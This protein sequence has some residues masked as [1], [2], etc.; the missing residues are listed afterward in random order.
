[1]NLKLPFHLS[2]IFQSSTSGK[3]GTIKGVLIP[4]ILQMIGVI[5]FMRLGW[6]LGSVGLVKMSMIITLSACLLFATGLSLTAIVSNMKMR[7]GGS[8]YII[9]RSLG[10]RFGSAIGILILISQLCS[11]ALCVTGF[12]LSFYEFFPHVPIQILKAGTLITLVFVSYFSTDFALKTQLFIFLSLAIAIASIFLGSGG[13]PETLVPVS[14]D[15][16]AITFWMGFALFFPAM[17]GIES[18]M[19]MSGDLSNPSRSLPLGTLGAIGIVY[20]IYMAIM[21]FLSFHVSSELLTS[22]PFILYH[23]SKVGYLIVMGI[24]AATLSSALGTIIGGPRVMQAVAKDGILPRFLAKG[25]GPTN[26]PRVATLTVSILALILTIATDINQIIPILSMSC[27]VS[28][29]LINFIAFFEIYIRN[30]SWRPGIR[31]PSIIPF[32][33]GMGCFMAMFMINPGATF[34]EIFLLALICFWGAKRKIMGNWDDLR[35]GILSYLVHKGTVKLSTLKHSAK[36]WR[37]H[38]LTIFDTPSVNKNLAFFAHAINQER[39]FLTFAASAIS[40]EPEKSFQNLKEDLKGFKIPSHIHGIRSLNP[41]EGVKQ[42]IQ[43][44]G[45]GFLKPNTVILPITETFDKRSFTELLLDTYR[46]EK[47]VILLKDDVQKDYLYNDPLRKNKQINLWWRGKYPGNFELGLALAYLL[48][49]SHFW[50]RSKICIKTV[51]KDEEG[52]AKLIEQFNRYQLKL[53]IA[54]LFF[55]PLIDSEEQFFP[56]LLANSKDGDLTFLGLKKPQENTTLEEYQEY[57]SMLLE[58]TSGLN[59]IAFILCGEKFRFRKIFI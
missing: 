56:N 39:G 38:I 25:Y 30:P 21:V 55:T 44:Y 47:N 16:S 26:Q 37:P 1:M 3:F 23:I 11:I 53:R 36:S 41:V 42:I 49:Q 14:N 27:L 48:Q 31:V 9:S 5:L 17:T 51:T 6:V 45:F 54:D 22:Y 50:P 18:G 29:A 34:I 4:N 59:N 32:F 13:A 8:Y 20:S 24:W 33:G 35:Q 10:M 15:P 2:S 46:Q 7:A 19:S 12:S 52:K 57:Y 43:N 28:Y 58:N 40:E